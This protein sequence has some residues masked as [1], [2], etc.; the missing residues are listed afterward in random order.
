M[1]WASGANNS[2]FC[3]PWGT[4][5]ISRD[6]MRCDKI[7]A[8]WKQEGSVTTRR[9]QREKAGWISGV[10][11]HNST[12]E[13]RW[14]QMESKPLLVLQV[15]N[16]FFFINL[17]QTS[18]KIDFRVWMTSAQEEMSK[19]I[20]EFLSLFLEVIGLAPFFPL[21]G[22]SCPCQGVNYFHVLKRSFHWK[23]M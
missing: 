13:E 19:I 18:T 16:Y 8:R 5:V 23:E 10:L 2:L 1:K 9:W 7:A 22:I 4:V 6:C 11:R 14:S 20:F 17:L 21:A 3:G 15:E 12:G